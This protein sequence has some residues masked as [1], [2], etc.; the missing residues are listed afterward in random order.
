[1]LLITVE[2]SYGFSPRI[3]NITVQCV[4]IC[5]RTRTLFK[6][7]PWEVIIDPVTTFRFRSED[8]RIEESLHRKRLL[9]RVICNSPI[10]IG[11]RYSL[12]SL[13]QGVSFRGRAR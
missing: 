6:A 5:L 10:N 13:K 7:I 8:L 3:I 4:I 12:H 11:E 1:M 9:A 2:P